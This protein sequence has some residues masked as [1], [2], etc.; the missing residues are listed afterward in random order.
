VDLWKTTPLS[1]TI[2]GWWHIG[3]GPGWV[4]ISPVSAT[5]VTV[6]IYNDGSN[7]SGQVTMDQ[8]DG[9]QTY[10]T[11][12]HA[13]NASLTTAFAFT[14]DPRDSANM[15]ARLTTDGSYVDFTLSRYY[16]G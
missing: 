7:Y 9:S 14:F 12:Y 8:T 3:T 2:A 6:Y 13:Y 5:Q 15:A 16:A 10:G 4:Y 1:E 11:F